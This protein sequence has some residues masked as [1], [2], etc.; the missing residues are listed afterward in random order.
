MTQEQLQKITDAVKSN[1]VANLA[2]IT[3][4]SKDMSITVNRHYLGYTNPRV[5]L[6]IDRLEE[7]EIGYL[8]FVPLLKEGLVVML[9]CTKDEE[10]AVE[11]NRS[12]SGTTA[13]VNL[14]A[15]L[16]GFD[17]EFTG[18][19][20]LRLP[21]GTTT[22]AGENPRKVGLLRVKRPKRKRSVTRKKTVPV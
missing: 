1:R 20:K 13:T 16:I 6:E 10:G 5:T 12:A 19:R 17:L 8:K 22:T 7:T 9:S 3:L 18:N 15:A 14:R 21:F 2:E 11:F 4:E